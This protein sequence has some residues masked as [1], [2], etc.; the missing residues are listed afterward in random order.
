L[1]EETGPDGKTMLVSFWPAL[2]PVEKLLEQKKMMGSL[3]F[4]T[5]K[6]NNP[7]NEEGVFQEDW[8]KFYHPE[9]L[10]GKHLVVAG[11]FD[12][13]VE[14]NATSDYKSI[15]T[16]GWDRRD[17]VYYVLDAYIRKA[18][19]DAAIAAAYARHEQWGYWQFG[20]E[21]V[22]FQKLLLREF[23][24]AAQQRGFHLPIRGTGQ[25]INKETRISGLSP[26]VERGQ[27]RF[28]RGQGNQDLLIEQLLYFPSK[29]VN[30]DGPDA[31]EG[32]LSLLEGG[33]GMGLFDFYR[34]EVEKMQAEEARRKGQVVA[35]GVR[36]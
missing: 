29:T 22:A 35:A 9:E 11:F 33:A 28:C 25:T 21:V 8:F 20:V 26:K 1:N 19:I 2:H 4:N 23:D 36:G 31:L 7:V 17:M 13:S 14:A 6:Q 18:S 32:A 16:V 27:I 34:D 15:L 3:A 24:R 5:E 30:D 12:P 10:R